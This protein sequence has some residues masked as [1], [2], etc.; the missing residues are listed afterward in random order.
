MSGALDLDHVAFFFFLP[1]F[2]LPLLSYSVALSDL[3]YPL[4]F[5]FVLSQFSSKDHSECTGD[6]SGTL[7][8]T[9]NEVAFNENCL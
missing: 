2:F 5:C 8:S 3:A 7:N 9:Y 1:F 6:K 4:Y